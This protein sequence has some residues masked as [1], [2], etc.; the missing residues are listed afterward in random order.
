MRGFLRGRCRGEGGQAVPVVAVIVALA[1]LVVVLVADLGR[2]AVA[3][4]R[5]RA[6]A[7]AAALAGVPDGRS[8]AAAIAE[9]NGGRLTSF[10]ADA[11][12]VEVVVEVDGARATARAEGTAAVSGGG[13]DRAGLAPAMVA[14][15]RRA[16]AL[17][18]G[19][20]PVSSGF[21]SR[22][23]QER[24]WV[25]R[26]RNP[27]PVAVPGTS[28]HERGMAIDVPSWFVP[29]LL[30]VA[31]EAGLCQPLPATDPVHFVPCGGGPT[32]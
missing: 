19:P 28:A 6:A 18:G 8:G 26:H 24:L 17:L 2:A 4:A 7:D 23:E 13:G 15:L 27:Y 1:C 31:A 5:A 9:A 30:T 20:V 22:A 3:R 29:V 12:T 32:E 21:R 14:A 10:R 25:N 16:D 11:T